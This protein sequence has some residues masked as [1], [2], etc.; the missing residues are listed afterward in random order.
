MRSIN[1]RELL[2][3]A[4]AMGAATT[5]PSF[6]D[7]ASGTGMRLGLVTYQW[8]KDMDLPTVISTC[9]KSGLTGV[10]LRTM[11]KHGVEPTLSKAQRAEVK[12][13]FADSKVTLVG[14]G[15][16]CEYH[17][18]D[19]AVVKK[20]IED[21]KAYVQL[22]HDCGGSGVKVK[23]NNLPKGVSREKTVE[24][25]GKA[26]NEVAAYAANYGQKIRVEVHGSL[27]QNPTVMKEI[28]DVATHKNCYICWNSNDEDL[29]SPGLEANFNMLKG[30][31]GDTV[32]V[33]EL[34][35]GDYPYPQLMKLFKAM[36]YKGW[37]LLEARTEPA[38]KVAAMKH[39][40]DVFNKLIAS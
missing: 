18:P 8:A 39:Q 37:L 14:Y 12:K 22:M 27:T 5:I 32:H 38:D 9:E 16:N 2:Q 13:R 7:A 4:A 24:Q 33:R 29:V 15:S 20:N 11:H 3:L 25:I 40:L 19:P 30:R 36:N 10:E 35:L 21:T 34:D 23:P 26:F 31:F 28:F 1:R 6:A 17:S